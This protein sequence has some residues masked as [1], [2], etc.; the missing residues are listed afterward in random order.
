MDQWLRNTNVVKIVALIIGILL[1]AVVRM[2]GG[3][4]TGTTSNAFKEEKI[5]NVAVTPKYDSDQYF[6]EVIDPAQVTV[7]ISGRDSVLFKVRNTATYS[8][9]VDLTNVGKGEHTLPLN[10]VGF[11]SNVTVKLSPSTVRVVV[12][13]KKNKSMPVTVNV[14]GIPAVGMKA[15]T[16]IVKPK[17]VTV[18]VPSGTYDKVD[19]VR[20]DVN[21]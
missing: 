21:V 9:E 12:D 3:S 16:P 4:M 2:D 6:V 17:Q 15:G 5:W 10:P 11:P 20:A 7:S 1:W 13:E 14:T 18:S 8:I 19:T